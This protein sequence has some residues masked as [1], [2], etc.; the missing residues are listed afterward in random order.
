M[1][2][3][4][5]DLNCPSILPVPF[6]ITVN[7]SGTTPNSVDGHPAATTHAGFTRISKFTLTPVVSAA[8][9]QGIEDLFPKRV[10]NHIAKWDFGDGY[11]LSGADV[12]TA[13]HIY[14]IPG[15]HTVS[16]FLYDKDSNAYKSTFTETISIY[17]YANTSIAVETR[18]ITE[19]DGINARKVTAGEL[20][21][22]NMETTA[23]WQDIPDPDEPQTFFFTSSGSMAKPYD[24]NNKYGHIVPYNAFY[25]TYN[26]PIN[27]VYGLKSILYPHY[28][29]INAD[30]V[31]VE[32]AK[33][34]SIKTDAKILY[35]STDEYISSVTPIVRRPIIFKYFDD[36]PNTAVNLLIR[37]DTS[38]HRIQNFYV[39]DIETDINNS[40]R[41]FLETDIAR[42]IIKDKST[43]NKHV[44]NSIGIPVKVITPFTSRLSF[45]S[46]GMREMSSI[47]YKR[48]GDKFQVFIALADKK[49]NIGKYYSPFFH[50]PIDNFITLINGD[51]SSALSGTYANPSV[52]TVAGTT[53]W[54]YGDR[55]VDGGLG[56]AS[57]WKWDS[58]YA[59]HAVNSLN[60]S[61]SAD[62]LYQDVNATLGN[63]Y[64]VTLTISDCTAGHV[65]VFLGTSDPTP[66]YHRDGLDED[67]TYT[68]LVDADNNVP[69]R[70]YIQAS[71]D[72]VGKVD[73]ISIDIRQFY[74]NWS[75]GNTTITSNISSL[76][77]TDLPF[78]TTSNKTELSSF[79]YLNIDPLSAGTWTLN[80][81]GRLDSFES[82]PADAIGQT[83]DY[84]PAGPLGPVSIGIG[85]TV[86]PGVIV[87]NLIT[88]SYTFT[89]FPS[90]NDVE[91][92]KI[93]EDTDY[94]EIL[95]SYRFQ[96]LQHEYDKLFDGIFTSFVGQASSSPTTFGK[97][98]FEKIANFTMNNSD[99]DFCKIKTL[100]SFYQF[101]NE[102]ID[103]QLPT[104]PS[105]LRRLYDLFSI[106]ISKL[107]G[108]YERYDTSF[109][110]Q[111]YT[112]SAA[113]RNIDLN[114]P[115]DPATY[116]VT[117]GTK[118]VAR[119]KFNNEFILINP[120]KVPTIR[121]DGS[122]SGVSTTYALNKYNVYSN[123]G[124]PLD[125]TISGSDGLSLFY[126]FYPYTNYNIISAE[127]IQN[128]IIDYNNKYN[129]I[130][131]ASSSLSANWD[132]VGG[133][134][135]K[136][137]DYQIRKG[138]QL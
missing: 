6:T 3:S 90:T 109:D 26:N 136:N 73:N 44:G 114:N 108:D 27:N 45:T 52:W 31:L 8:E 135:F 15:I 112:S 17:N 92:Y 33:R 66:P 99:V 103:I 110:T 24:F 119:Q 21:T 79:L 32:C 138:L 81:T 96:T 46:T 48:Q 68:I 122:S 116:T 41:T 65:R 4:T 20:K 113:S 101:F 117:A 137:L 61:G 94:S 12:F 134:V 36:I 14:N 125:T 40:N 126:E 133:I 69:G 57:G 34:D 71:Y 78:N 88:G 37:I 59:E 10:S 22:F 89:V 102:D 67:G 72:F 97:T 42:P 2:T 120:Q 13:T 38:R 115:I 100:E 124:W 87:N 91:I 104:A 106:K 130:T 95:K 63:E 83:I 107:L 131:R 51:F 75:D 53:G 80:I 62:N 86:P 93:N 105:E 77:T 25:D 29:Y 11:T 30:S 47:E 127:N 82:N 19:Q 49:L 85:N 5:T 54:T 98:I 43:I 39:D 128:N 56:N 23:S 84:D 60:T 70:L 28:F 35:S 18:N 111:F 118:F 55:P 58:G 50:E 1:S 64:K 123:W 7:T 76:C 74:Y 132:P 121:V 16:I 9:G 129:T